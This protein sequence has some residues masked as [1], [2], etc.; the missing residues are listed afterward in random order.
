MRL[1][2]LIP[3]C[4]SRRLVVFLVALHAIALVGFCWT[5]LWSWPVV[6]PATAL[7]LLTLR[8]SLRASPIVALRLG[9]KGDLSCLLVDGR[10]LAVDLLPSATVLLGVVVLRFHLNGARPMV[11]ALLSDSFV[12]AADFRI[13]K[14]WLR[15]R[16]LTLRKVGG[17]E[18][19]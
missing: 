2:R 16:A 11:L 4:R 19:G 18:E 6:V 14:V 15:A 17:D 5:F 9:I 10:R 3:L 13:L 8:A 7:F 12:V 1:P